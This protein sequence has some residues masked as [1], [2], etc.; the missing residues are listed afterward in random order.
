MS[1]QDRYA[2]RFLIHQR[3]RMS[4]ER[5]PGERDRDRILYSTAFR[6]LSRVTQVVSPNERQILHNRLT[7][8]LEVAQIARALANRLIASSD[9]SRV[10]QAGGIDPYIVEAAALS[11]DLGHPPFGH[12]AESELDRILQK[13]HGLADGFEGNAQSFR[14]VTKLAARYPDVDGLNLCRSTLAAILKYPWLRSDQRAESGKKPKW[15]A[16]D[17]E[18]D[19]LKWATTLI[20]PHGR[21]R[22][23]EAAIMDWADDIAYAVSDLEDFIRAGLIPLGLLVESKVER[24][25]FLRSEFQDLAEN[26]FEDHAN[27]LT[28]LLAFA[29][30]RFSGS[31]TDR[32]HLR[33]FTSVLINRYIPS[34]SLG[35]NGPGE[36]S[37]LIND[38]ARTE[39]TVLKGLTWH[40]VIRRNALSTLRFGQ[41]RIIGDL[42]AIL[43]EASAHRD[44]HAIFPL[45]SRE[46]L[47][48]CQSDQERARVVADTIASMNES[49]AIEI[50]QRLT[51]SILGSAMDDMF[52]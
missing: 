13:E 17:S 29:P 22:S 21:L 50:H 30:K 8:S 35:D 44:D 36:Q 51:G 19:D 1:E 34:V 38:K 14:V 16:Y 28:S 15:G 46:E 18:A 31:R 48:R 39:V 3:D 52:I 6:R 2:R 33:S 7:H 32:A 25:N 26:E 42:F 43:H 5:L 24:Q 37:L 41:R 27:A 12:V 23:I 10:R 45:S 11:H 47:E 40:Y 4:D 20:D 49:Q 9:A